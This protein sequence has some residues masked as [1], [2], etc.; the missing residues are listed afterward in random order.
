MAQMTSFIS[1]DELR[2]EF[3]LAMSKMY[4]EEVPLYGDLVKIVHD[5]N[6]ATVLQTTNT[7]PIPDTVALEASTERLTLERHGAIRLGTPYELQTVRRIF[8]VLGMQPMGY[9]DLSVAGLPMHA[10]CFRPREISSLDRNPF[11]VFTTLLRPELLASET[12]REQALGLLEQR[13]IF[14]DRLLDLLTIAE[15]QGTRLTNEQAKTFIPEALL[16]FS[17]RSLAAATFDQYQALRDEHPILADIACFQ[18]AHINH[19]TPR[20]LNITAVQAAMQSAGMAVKSRIEGPPLRKCPILLRQTSFLALQ[21]MVHFKASPK[22]DGTELI[23]GSHTARFGEIEERG[24][25]VTP[26]GR[27]LYDKLLRES[28]A[29]SAGADLQDVDAIVADVFKQYPD[30]WTEL[31]Q[32]GLIYCEYRC[33]NKKGRD[34]LRWNETASVLEQLIAE[35]FV[36]ASP[37]TYEDFLPFSAAGIFQSNLRSQDKAENPLGLQR[38]TADPEGLARALQE[39]PMDIDEW[40]WRVQRQSLELFTSVLVTEVS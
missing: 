34:E 6:A 39:A 36:E 38:G 9:Y 4:K 17:W 7:D 25:A 23:R 14:T 26:K 5:I 12:A 10:T 33:I 21:E 3:A 16:S 30:D 28:M 40:Y 37:I 13:R 29:K 18:S 15:A 1:A 24:A 31:R 2:T 27:E 19:L 22:S 8:A 20:T 35:G 32:Q 11:R